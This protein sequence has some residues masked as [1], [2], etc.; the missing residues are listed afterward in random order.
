M[1]KQHLFS[2]KKAYSP[3]EN[4]AE[5]YSTFS[6][7]E[8]IFPLQSPLSHRG[9]L[10]R[11]KLA[12]QSNACEG[13]N[14]GNRAPSKLTLNQKPGQYFPIPHPSTGLRSSNSGSQL[15]ELQD[16][17]SLPSTEGSLSHRRGGNKKI[18]GILNLSRLHSSSPSQI[19]IDPLNKGYQPQLPLL[20][21]TCPATNKN[22]KA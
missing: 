12:D 19:S 21:E 2:I 17:L 16:R 15:Q 1:K 6:G 13:H 22:Y 20:H 9:H 18:R 5:A 7:R 8:G 11:S 4:T 3:G 10:K 14:P